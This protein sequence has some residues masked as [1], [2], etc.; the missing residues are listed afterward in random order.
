LYGDAGARTV[1]LAHPHDLRVL[2][3]D[4]A[5]VLADVDRGSDLRIGVNGDKRRGV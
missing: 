2:V 3:V 4:D 1:L 5:G